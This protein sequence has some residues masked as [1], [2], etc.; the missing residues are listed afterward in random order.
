MLVTIFNFEFRNL[1]VLKLNVLVR[2]A[3]CAMEVPKEVG[4]LSQPMGWVCESYRDTWSSFVFL[5][6]EWKWKVSENRDPSV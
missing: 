4:M 6:A 3:T 2:H 1:L 5:W